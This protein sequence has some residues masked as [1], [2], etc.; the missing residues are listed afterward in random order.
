MSVEEGVVEHGQELVTLTVEQQ[1]DEVVA[2]T[3]ERGEEEDEDAQ[4]GTTQEETR[5]TVAETG[6]ETLQ[7]RHD[8]GEVESHQTAE[9]T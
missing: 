1:V 5:V 3:I 8:T 2:L 9:Y 7:V 6:E 4:H